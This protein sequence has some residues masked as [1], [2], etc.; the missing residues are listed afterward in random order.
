MC[1]EIT[2]QIAFNS[3]IQHFKEINLLDPLVINFKAVDE[4]S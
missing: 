2:S 1:K 4:F 3:V